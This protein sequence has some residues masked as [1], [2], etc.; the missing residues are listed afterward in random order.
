MVFLAK[1]NQY[2]VIWVRL[3]LLI[4]LDLPALRIF[5]WARFK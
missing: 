4:D 1:I 3:C 5:S 2:L